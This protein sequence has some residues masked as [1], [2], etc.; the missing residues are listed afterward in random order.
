MA[1]Q[2]SGLAEVGV[3]VCACV[4]VF[5]C[6]GAMARPSLAPFLFSE[7]DLP[8]VDLLP[9]LIVAKLAKK[10]LQNGVIAHRFYVFVNTDPGAAGLPPYFDPDRELCGSRLSGPE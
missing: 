2:E 9:D 10:S 6:A 1:K 8:K 4:C 3:C 5:A 7:H